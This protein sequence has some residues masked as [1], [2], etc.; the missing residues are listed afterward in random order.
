MSLPSRERGLKSSRQ[1]AWPYS[2]VAPFT[3]AWIEIGSMGTY[4]YAIEV[5][6]FTG[7]WIEISYKCLLIC[8]SLVAPFTGAWIEIQI[9][10]L[11]KR[12]APVA[13]FTGAWIEITITRIGLHR[14]I[15]R[16]L[17]G[18]VD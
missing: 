6:P 3:G 10:Y 2:Y 1:T 7:A 13:P 12:H 5:A 15:C 14:T 16:S 9:G 18:S 4:E 11:D 17:H 8:H